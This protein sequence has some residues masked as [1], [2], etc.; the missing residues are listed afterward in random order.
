MAEYTIYST[1]GKLYE[2]K[3]HEID[4]NQCPI[5]FVGHGMPDYGEAQNTNFLRLLENYCYTNEPEKPV[6]GQFWFRE[7]IKEDDSTTYEMRICKNPDGEELDERWDKLPRYITSEAGEEPSNPQDSDIWYD[8]TTHSLKV[9]DNGKWVVIGPTD[10]EHLMHMYSST[11]ITQVSSTARY[12]IDKSVFARDVSNDGDSFSTNPQGS[13]NLLTMKVMIKEIYDAGGYSDGMRSYV[14]Q[15][16]TVIQA[17]K[18]GLDDTNVSYKLYMVG[19]PIYEVLAKSEDFNFNI[20]MYLNE[21]TGQL[22]VE[23][24]PETSGTLSTTSHCVIGFDSDITR[25]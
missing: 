6:K 15:I 25:V 3:E 23:I 13:L 22:T 19:A 2:I 21:D 24:S 9:R 10:A 12:N 17:N 16:R 5:L 8:F 4:P 11:T 7:I 14:M 20:Q 18:I 1:S